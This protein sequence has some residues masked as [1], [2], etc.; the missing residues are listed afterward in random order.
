LT[1]DAAYHA[2]LDTNRRALHRAAAQVLRVLD[3]PGA[4]GE[5]A[6]LEELI[7]HASQGTDWPLAH[8]LAGRLLKLKLSG[9]DRSGW[10]AVAARA[11]EYWQRARAADPALPVESAQL[12]MMRGDYARRSGDLPQA[13]VLLQRALD[14][15]RAGQD[16]HLAASILNTLGLLAM[17][18]G[19]VGRA[20]ELFETA[21]NESR[22]AGDPR[23][24]FLNNLAT[25]YAAQGQPSRAAACLDEALALA[26]AEGNLNCEGLIYSSLGEMAVA[27]GQ[28]AAAA[29][30]HARELDIARLTGVLS[31]EAWALCNLGIV[32][33][34]QGQLLPA[35]GYLRAAL[36]AARTI[37]AV[38]LLV[39]VLGELAA[40]DARHGELAEA[41]ALLREALALAEDQGDLRHCGKFLGQLGDLSFRSGDAARGRL[42]YAAGKERLDKS[43]DQRL[44]RELLERWLASETALAVNLGID[45]ATTDAVRLQAELK[46][47]VV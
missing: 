26:R 24:I 37:R 33:A 42:H 39:T 7:H 32:A 21:L 28:L 19:E 16:V 29:D 6:L 34:R 11:E 44:L 10:H 22:R 40:V 2:L 14:V 36:T 46:T 13:Q 15:A 8:R 25:I 18:T 12:L 27:Q 1:R 43:G 31:D 35:Q 23:P 38:E 20:G 47:L 5:G 3:V 4:P 45:P 41:E 9:G 30:W 17:N